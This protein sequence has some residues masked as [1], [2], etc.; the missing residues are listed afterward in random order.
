MHPMA[1][2]P[3]GDSADQPPGNGTGDLITSPIAAAD[4]HM[5][6]AEL[7]QVAARQFMTRTAGRHPGS[8]ASTLLRD[9]ELARANIAALLALVRRLTRRPMETG[10]PAHPE[11]PP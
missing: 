9:V 11:P 5:N 7:A 2:N 4:G 8:A 1:A 3:P 6:P 10:Q